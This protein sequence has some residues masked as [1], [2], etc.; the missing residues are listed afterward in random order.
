MNRILEQYFDFGVMF[1]PSNFDKVID[2]FVFTIKL[3]IIAG[4][5][6][7][8]WG[9]ILAILRQTPGPAELDRA[10]ADDR[11]HRRAARRSGAAHDPAR[12][13]QPRRP[14]GDRSADRARAR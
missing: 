3:S 7:L 8:I 2:G 14:G 10:V 11:L 6:S 5:A 9:L 4:I 1:D 12:L 13:D